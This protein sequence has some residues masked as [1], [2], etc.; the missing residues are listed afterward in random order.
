[1]AEVVIE[2]VRDGLVVETRIAIIF[3]AAGATAL[4]RL[5]SPQSVIG[6]DQVEQA[7]VIV[8]EPRRTDAQR[9]GR[10]GANAGKRRHVGE[11]SVAVVAI[12]HVP[13]RAGNKDVR[14]SVVVVIADGDAG[15]VVEILAQ[16]S[17]LPGDVFKR[18]VALVA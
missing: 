2:P 15:V 17:G 13:F 9:S 1:M 6:D 12:E 8:I 14:I 11:R 7:V 10:L 18:A 5:R 16:Q 3:H 4:V